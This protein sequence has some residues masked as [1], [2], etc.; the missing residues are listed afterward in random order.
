VF[1]IKDNVRILIITILILSILIIS[2]NSEFTTTKANS[3]FDNNMNDR[4]TSQVSRQSISDWKSIEVISEPVLG[5]DF[6]VGLS[7][8]VRVAAEGNK[9]Y[10]VWHDENNTNGAGGGGPDIFYKHYDGNSW[11][12][13]QVISEPVPGQDNFGGIAPSIAVEDGKIYVVWDCSQ[14][15]YGSGTDSDIYFRCNLT[16]TSWEPIQVISEPVVGQNINT[17]YSDF[18]DIAVENGKIYVVWEDDNN[19]NGAGIESDIFY[20]ANLTG[21]G[22]ESVQVIS[23]PKIGYNID[24][25][26]SNRPKIDVENGKIYSVWY[27][28]NDTNGAGGDYDIFYRTN[29][30]GSSWEPVQVISE[31]IEGININTGTSF[32]PRIAVENSKIYL[33]WYDQTGFF[34]SGS[35]Y[36]IFYRCN[37][38]GSG[39]EDIQVISEPVSG[40]DINTGDSV[41]SSIDIDNGKI[42]VAW[43]DWNDTK[44][45]G[46]DADIFYRANL[47]GLSWEPVQ[48]I[49]EPVE[50]KN[51]NSYSTDFNHF[52]DVAV[53]ANSVHV[54]WSDENNSLNSGTDHD[55]FYRHI[56]SEL[57][58]S[59]GKVNP[60][61]GNTSTYFNY[62]VKYSHIKNKAPT[63]MTICINGIEYTMLETDPL[64]IYYKDGKNYFFNI[65]NLDIGLNNFICNTSDG[66]NFTN[67]KMFSNPN[68]INTIPKIITE[69]NFT[70]IE[71]TYYEVQYEYVD[72]DIENVG[73]VS[74]WNYSTNASWL[75]FDTVTGLLN[76]IPSND[77]VGT[78]W[79]NISINDTIDIDFTNFTVSVLNNNDDPI[80]NTTNIVTA[81]EDELYEVDYDAIDVDSPI[82]DQVWSLDTN[83]TSWL[84]IDSNSGIISGIPTNDDVG[85]YWVNVS[86]NDGNKGLA[87]TNFTLIVLNVN[88]R[89]E[90]ITGDKLTANPNVPYMVDYDASDIDSPLSQLSWS[91]NTNATWLD[92]DTT[93]GVLSGTPTINNVGWFNVNITVNDGDGGQDWH[94]FVLTVFPEGLKNNPP[95]ITTIDIVSITAGKSYNV[96]YQATDDR[97]PFDSLI[98]SYNSNAS[99]L[100][101]NKVT[102]SLTGN[103]ALTNVGWYWVN[104]TVNDGESGFDSHNFTLTVWATANQLP[105]ILTEDD[106]NAVVDELYSVDYDAEDDRTP[107][108]YLQWSVKTNATWLSMQTNT[109]VLAGTPTSDDVGWFQVNVT[110]FDGEDGWDWHRFI[111]TVSREPIGENNAPILTNPTMAPTAGDTNTEFTFAVHYFDM[112]GDLP[113]SIEVVIDGNE[114]NM[115]LKVGEYTSNGIYIYKTKLS[116]GNHTYYFTASDGIETV[117]TNTFTTNTINLTKKTESAILAPSVIETTVIFSFLTIIIIGILIVGTE[118]GK[119]RFLSLIFVPLYNK[120]HPDKIFDNYTRGKIHGYIEAKPGEHYNA[121]KSALK[122]KNGTL[123]HHTKVL[124]KEGFISIKRDGF[125]TRFY[126][127]GKQVNDPE[128]PVIIETQEEIIDMIRHQPGITQREIMD[129]VGLSQSATSYNLTWL[130]RNNL[131]KCVKNGRE[132]KYYIEEDEPATSEVQ[133]KPQ[134]DNP[135]TQDHPAQGSSME[136]GINLS[137]IDK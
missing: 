136:T 60:I 83:A 73:Q 92:L 105:D 6:N 103:P 104:V 100:S 101:F 13:I 93:T 112:D 94:E 120:L 31:P 2:C 29:L 40:Q 111:L 109:G 61:F 10:V 132:N 102:R 130:N 113:T 37:L 8:Y 82:L 70:A 9:I 87:F 58:L 134:S 47:T 119:Y 133:E 135:I 33:V 57:C 43:A 11:S 88:D 41:R 78:Y 74:H 17:D 89:P 54:L 68:V 12:E 125:Y 129:Y 16:G 34:N 32:I 106:I 36:D 97:T 98:W 53:K 48:V 122:L 7:D 117:S 30:T 127:I 80:I 39:W 50:G 91:L 55:I 26:N 64:D 99:W 51:Y 35:D 110:V 116:K 84:D 3:H 20:R 96:I 107:E 79:V 22:W 1:E 115:T 42:H 25:S 123:T 126:P 52:P 76:G 21:L 49:S 56:P 27:S 85:K 75:I 66:V 18:P 69:D 63:K 86:V 65:T 71:D 137:K 28:A 15:L 81:T 4:S 95:V 118:V 45:A 124:E 14:N 131:V 19:T 67:T 38:S 59:L 114:Y 5:Q 23:E 24:I 77:D 62:T 72:I 108:E 121:I 128:T 90:I 46:T 44:G